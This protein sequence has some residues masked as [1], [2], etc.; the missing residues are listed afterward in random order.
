MNNPRIKKKI[1]KIRKNSQIIGMCHGV[2]DLVHYGHLKHFEAAKEKCDYLFVSITPDEHI[3]KGPQ[4]P[5]HTTNERV[6]F[7]K[8]LKMIDEVIVA[9][10]DSAVETINLIRPNIYFKGNDYKNNKLDKTKKIYR[11]IH[12]VKKIKGKI[13]YTNEKQLSSSKII[14]QLSLALNEKQSN[15]LKKLKEQNDYNDIVDSINKVKKTKVLVV[16][17]LI[18]DRYVFGNVLGKSGKEPHMVFN[19]IKEDMHV[20]GSAIVA[21]H[22]SDFVKKISLISDFGNE[23]SIKKLLYKKLKK[24]ITHITLKP[25]ENYKTS[26]KTRFIDSVS[27]YKL[28]GSYLIPNLEVTKFYKI[29]TK[30]L[31]NILNNHDV[32]IITDYSNNFFDLNSLKKIKQSKKFICGMAQKNSNNSVFHTLEHLK[33]IDLLCIN[34]GELRSE[35]RDKQNDI[36][37]I[38]KKYL[39]KNNLKY[40]VVTKGI[41]G[42]ILF[43]K[44]F[45]RYYCPSFNSKP[46]DKVGAGDS[47][48]AILSIFLKNKINPSVA[49]LIASLVSSNVVN[50]IGNK[51]SASKIEIDRSIEY[52][53]K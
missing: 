27:N 38:A 24:N 1:K 30:S 13:I 15:F 25:S 33:D 29:L 51:Y 17:D 41:D 39:K 40:L 48:L 18:I 28:F 4:R 50:N 34:E 53:F 26:I 20:G 2:F 42:S 8:S 7:L 46:I 10:G 44:K 35:V 32:V 36:E 47:M 45:N 37:L 11:E 9:K 22:L 6:K 5:I 16:G 52:L 23:N 3:K 12:A 21:N 31:V 19:Q 43:D 49:L 14:N